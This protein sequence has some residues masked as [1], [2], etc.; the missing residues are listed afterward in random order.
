MEKLF[1]ETISSNLPAPV[2]IAVFPNPTSETIAFI[3]EDNLQ[4]LKLKVYNSLGEL[5][6]FEKI[7][8]LEGFVLNCSNWSGGTYFISLTDE[9]NQTYY[10]KLTKK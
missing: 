1:V 2:Q 4:N 8:Q 5:I 7:A 3:T 6:R 10:S 9:T